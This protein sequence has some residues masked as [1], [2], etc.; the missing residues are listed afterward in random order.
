MEKIGSHHLKAYQRKRGKY[1]PQSRDNDS[2]EFRIICEEHCNPMGEKFTGYKPYT[3]NHCGKNDCIFENLI[4]P[5][6]VPGSKIVA[7]NRLHSLVDSHYN[8]DKKCSKPVND[9]ISAYSKVSTM[10]D[11]PLVKDNDYYT[12]Y[13]IH[14]KRC[15]SNL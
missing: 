11:K 12:G 1:Y 6:H 3:Y 4:D 2:R 14:Q 7:C 5:G 15:S 9:T 8:H 10:L 13:S